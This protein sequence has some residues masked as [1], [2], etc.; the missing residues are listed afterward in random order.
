MQVA[1]L[2]T[3]STVPVST[4]RTVATADTTAAKLPDRVAGPLL[5]YDPIANMTILQ[6]VD[7]NSGKVTRQIPTADA[8]Q[9]Y[10]VDAFRNFIMGKD[11][12]KTNP[13]AVDA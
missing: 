2:G 13:V 8:L 12:P 4:D 5:T 9:T 1:S 10:Q 6:Y 11:S 7:V 3:A